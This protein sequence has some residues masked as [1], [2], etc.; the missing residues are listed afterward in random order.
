MPRL[1][2]RDYFARRQFLQELWFDH[3]AGSIGMIPTDMQ[4]DLHDFFALTEPLT[5]AEVLQHRK[6]MSK[7]FPALPQQAGRAYEVV[8][9]HHD[10]RPNKTVDECLA[11]PPDST[12]QVAGGRN[13]DRRVRALPLA[14]PK[15]DHRRLAHG[16]LEFAKTPDGQKLYEEIKKR[17]VRKKSRL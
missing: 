4:R 5:E 14:R 16:L 1:T 3:A 6:E 9:A 11:F 2:S 8:L 12:V 17:E 10:G 7:A 13:K 15:I